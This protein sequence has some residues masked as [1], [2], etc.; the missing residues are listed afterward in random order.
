M[1]VIGSRRC[2]RTSLA[3]ELLASAIASAWSTPE[4]AHPV[5]AKRCVRT[6]CAVMLCSG[7]WPARAAPRRRIPPQVPR[8][9]KIRRPGRLA[10]SRPVTVRGRSGNP[11]LPLCPITGQTAKRR[12]QRVSGVLLIAL[13]QDFRGFD[14]A[15][16]S[17]RETVCLVGVTL[18][19]SLLPLDDCRGGAILP[20]FS[21]DASAKAVPG[22]MCSSRG[23]SSPGSPR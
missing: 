10:P 17:R 7:A 12:I 20:R 2:G 5:R 11:L 9:R 13:W 15:A 21:M 23:P 3:P 8:A 18:R 22:E 1:F 6:G 14:S 19:A 16:A 4:L